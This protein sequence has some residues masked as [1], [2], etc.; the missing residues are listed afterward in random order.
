[1]SPPL[2]ELLSLLAAVVLVA[3]VTGVSAGADEPD[4]DNSTE[5]GY[6]KGEIAEWLSLDDDNDTSQENISVDEDVESLVDELNERGDDGIARYKINDSGVYGGPGNRSKSTQYV[7]EYADVIYDTPP[8]DFHRWNREE[9]RDFEPGGGTTSRHPRHAQLADG[10]WIKDAHVTLFTIQPSTQT[11]IN[12]TRTPLYIPPNGE[13]LATADYRVREPSDDTNGSDGV[14]RFRSMQNHKIEDACIIKGLTEF[15]VQ[16]RDEPC[17][18]RPYVVGRGTGNL[19]RLLVDYSLRNIA[20][21]VDLVLAVE[22]AAQVEV[23]TKREREYEECNPKTFDNGTVTTVCKDKTK[24]VKTD[25][26]TET[27]EVVAT[28]TLSASVYDETAFNVVQG[29]DKTSGENNTVIRVQ[30]RVPWAGIESNGSKFGT[31]WRFYTHRE[32]DWDTIVN[33]SKDG[34]ESGPS[35]SVPIKAF[36]FPSKSNGSYTET[37]QTGDIIRDETYLSEQRSSPARHVPDT[38]GA[39]VAGENPDSP[40]EKYQTVDALQISAPNGTYESAEMVGL[41]AGETAPINTGVAWKIPIRPTRLQAEVVKSNSTYA[42]V[43]LNLTTRNGE[44]VDLLNRSGDGRVVLPGG[45]AVQTDGDGVVTVA[46]KNNDQGLVTFL[47]G[48][49]VGQPVGYERSTAR[50][51]VVPKMTGTEGLIAFFF[52]AVGLFLPGLAVLWLLDKTPGVETW[53]PLPLK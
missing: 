13:I 49:W 47:P 23:T 42:V 37:Y 29:I 50:Y 33:S 10:T 3:T 43:A 1:M 30:S 14:K 17:S 24:F 22:V 2:R 44:P 20:G 6:S 36:A 26:S 31:G 27:E 35:D 48:D 39:D 7:T 32:P 19:H 11:Y 18:E 9:V 5:H 28:D 38:I 21:D 34:T 8:S 52:T 46:I 51:S 40:D 4:L 45:R 16:N 15:Q 53:P 25:V 12:E 41:V